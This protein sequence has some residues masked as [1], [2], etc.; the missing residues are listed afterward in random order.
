V[1]IEIHLKLFL[2]SGLKGRIDRLPYC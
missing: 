2:D 1:N